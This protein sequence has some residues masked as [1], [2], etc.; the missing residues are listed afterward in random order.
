MARTGRPR[1]ANPS[2]RALAMREKRARA[3]AAAAGAKV[4]DIPT[5]TAEVDGRTRARDLR[6]AKTKRAKPDSTAKPPRTPDEA[7]DWLARV[8]VG[9]IEAENVQ[10]TAAKALLDSVRRDTPEEARKDGLGES[11]LADMRGWSR[12]PQCPSCGVTLDQGA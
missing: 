4:E 7:Q 3:K 1:H 6:R 12:P 5:R 8:A 9:E 11:M 2:P 10:V